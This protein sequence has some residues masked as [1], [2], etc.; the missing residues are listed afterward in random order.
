MQDCSIII[1]DDHQLFIEGLSALLRANQFEVLGHANSGRQLMT[2]LEKQ[3]PHLL[4]MDIGMKEMDGIEVAATIKDTYPHIKILI[5]SMHAKK[6]YLEKL[7]EIGAEGYILKSAGDE[8]L[9][10]AIYTIRDG[11][12]YFSPQLSESIVQGM[13]TRNSLP[14][15]ILTPREKEIVKLIAEGQNTKEI[16]TTLFI[17]INTVES[18]RKNMLLKTG[19][20]NVAHLVKWAYENGHL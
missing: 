6:V 8:E 19:L 3:Q 16:A 4:L 9:K 11:G 1:V 10:T 20:K 13:L 15:I 18:H 12:T 5:I 7:V 2:L 14:D 17:S